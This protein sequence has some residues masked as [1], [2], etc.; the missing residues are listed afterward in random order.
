MRP[1]RDPRECFHW[2]TRRTPGWRRTSSA[3]SRELPEAIPQR[4]MNWLSQGGRR[5]H[6]LRP[7]EARRRQK[8]PAP[9]SRIA[10]ASWLTPHDTWRDEDQ[11]L[12]ILVFVDV[13]LE[14]PS[15]ERNAMEDRRA[16]LA[17]V[18]FVDV[19]AADHRCRTVAHLNGGPGALGINRAVVADDLTDAAVLE[20]D[21]HNHSVGGGD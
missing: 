13:G 3:S 8:G 7:R 20:F 2:S 5:P 12:T 18:L 9:A 4:D 16:F 17:A 11:Q 1:A 6:N 19:D 15:Q 21:F 14:Q 10:R